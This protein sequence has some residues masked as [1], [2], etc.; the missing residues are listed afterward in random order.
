MQLERSKS[1][2]GMALMYR[3]ADNSRSE[4]GPNFSPDVIPMKGQITIHEVAAML[5]SEFCRARYREFTILRN[6][7]TYVQMRNTM[8]KRYMFFLILFSQKNLC[9]SKGIRYDWKEPSGYYFALN[10]AAARRMNELYMTFCFFFRG[11]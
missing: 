9:A 10:L 3:V 5:L 8:K 2:E 7:W 1:R 4:P 11:C 6:C